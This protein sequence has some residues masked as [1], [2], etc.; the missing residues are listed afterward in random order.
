MWHRLLQRLLSAFLTLLAITLLAFLLH[1]YQPGS[2][3]DAWCQLEGDRNCDVAT[4]QRIAHRLGLHLPLFYASVAPAAYPDSL[5]RLQPRA[6]RRAARQWLR[7]SGDW[8]ATAA[9]LASWEHCTAVALHSSDTSASTAAFRQMAPHW[10][11]RTDTSAWSRGW[12]QWDTAAIADT[13]LRT[14]LTQSHAAYDTL[15]AQHPQWQDLRPTLRWHGV[16]SQYHRWL[17]RAIRLDFGVSYHTGQPVWERLRPHLTWTMLLSGLSLALA[18]GLAIPIGVWSACHAGSNADRWINDGLFALYAL[19]SFWVATLAL[20]F[21]ASP[22]YLQ[23]FPAGGVSDL[24]TQSRG[25]MWA[26]WADY[27]WHLC[28]PVFCWTYPALAYLSRQMRTSMREALAQPYILQARAKGL[29]ERMIV[30]RYALRAAMLPIA[31]LLGN[32][33]PGLVTGSVVLEV[34]FGIPG[35]GKLLFDAIQ[36]QDIPVVMAC[37]VLLAVLTQ[38]G[39]WSSEVLYRWLDPRIQSSR[40]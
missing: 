37:V 27:A 16:A 6:H 15:L 10:H 1:H 11:Y 24:Y 17:V 12:Q 34:I 22:D 35:M 39:Y 40:L 4:R 28:L 25:G 5:H 7:R 36:L 9:F 3:V 32:V 19:P 31:T 18:Y 29:P 38:V 2:P 8:Q 26:R 33:L 30:W 20:F 21:L 13:A 14:A 23:W